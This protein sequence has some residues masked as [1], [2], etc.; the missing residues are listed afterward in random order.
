MAIATRVAPS[1]LR[2]G[3]IEL[4]ARRVRAAI[5]S[6]DRQMRLLELRKIV[7]HLIDREYPEIAAD[8]YQD[9]VTADIE[10]KATQKN[11]VVPSSEKCS[12]IAFQSKILVR[13]GF[14]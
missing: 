3:Q 4:F 11:D 14:V 12:E 10:A 13:K 2:V 6:K 5:D 8:V 1:F 7:L 9:I